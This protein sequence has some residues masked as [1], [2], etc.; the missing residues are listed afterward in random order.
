MDHLRETPRLLEVELHA[1]LHVRLFEDLADAHV[2]AVVD[3]LLHELV[4]ADAELAESAEPRP[5]IGEKAEEDPP[6]RIQ[7]L[8]PGKLPRIHL[9]HCLDHVAVGGKLLRAAV[10]FVDDPR[11]G[12]RES[13][14]ALHVL[15]PADAVVLRR[16][17]VEPHPAAGD[18]RYVRQHVVLRR[19]KES[20]LKILRV[21]ELPRVDDPRLLEQHTA[22]QAVE[23]RACDQSHVLPTPRLFFACRAFPISWAD[24]GWDRRPFRAGLPGVGAPGALSVPAAKKVCRERAVNGIILQQRRGGCINDRYAPKNDRVSLR[25]PGCLRDE[26]H[27]RRGVRDPGAE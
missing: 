23:I 21:D 6:L 7:Y 1:L 15:R 8:L 12:R 20:V 11:R 2:P 14:L 10:V 3:Q 17:V 5:G 13:A 27:V 9:V 4:V 18:V 22:D 26:G 19:L 25:L 16:M 24:P